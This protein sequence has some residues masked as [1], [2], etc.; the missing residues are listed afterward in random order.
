M[1]VVRM[2]NTKFNNIKKNITD[3]QENIEKRNINVIPVKANM[4]IP[5]GKDYFNKEYSLNDLKNHT[6]NFGIIAG[7]K[8][9][10]INI[11][12]NIE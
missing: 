12:G 10:K 1:D 9:V 6:G 2:Y 5:V 3:I 7:D 4:K 11:R 8:K